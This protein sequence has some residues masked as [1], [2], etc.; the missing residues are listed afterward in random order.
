MS[1]G[2]RRGTIATVKDPERKREWETIFDS[3]TL[4]IRSPLPTWV[5]LPAMGDKLA[6][7][8]DLKRLTS[9]QR[10]RLVEH[11]IREF[12]PTMTPDEVMTQLM[13]EGVQIPILAE[14]VLVTGF[15]VGLFL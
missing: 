15:D 6:Y 1:E 2:Q 8:L 12:E 7:E 5:D 11:I 14:D 9:K 3:D 4:P 13:A 10:G